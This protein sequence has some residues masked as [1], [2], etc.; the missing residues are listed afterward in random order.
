M[1]DPSAIRTQ[2][3][4]EH[5]EGFPASEV[6]RATGS[7][8]L[9]GNRLE[10]Q[11]EGSS[12]FSSWLEGISRAQC[13]VYLENYLIRNDRVGRA[14]RDVLIEKARSGVPVYVIYD[15]VGCWATRSSYWKPLRQAGVHVRAFNPLS[16]GIGDPFGILRRDHRKLIVLDGK[17]AYVGGFCLGVEWVGGVNQPAWR[18]TAVKISGPAASAAARAFEATWCGMGESL[19]LSQKLPILSDVG[20]TP[21]WLIEGE[22]GRTRVYRTIHWVAARA[23][24][25]I[26][27]TDAYFV[28]PRS[29]SEALGAAAQQGVDVRILV[30]A[31]NNW[32]L[33]GSLS[34][35]GYRSLLKSGVR[36]FEWQGPMI[37]AKTAV[38]DGIWSRVGSSN[39]NSA[40]LIGNW[41]LD[42][43]VLDTKLASQLEDLFLTDLSSSI[44]IVLPGQKLERGIEMSESPGAT[45]SL[46]PQGTLPERMMQIRALGTTQSRITMAPLVRARG[47]LGDSLAGDRPIGREGRTVLGTVSAII[48]STAIIAAFFPTF[49]GAMVAVIAGWFGLTTGIRAY[50]QSRRARS[51]E[52]EATT[53]AELD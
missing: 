51:R 8:T 48:L 41:E 34:R 20:D 46:D 47:A 40:S 17:V 18:D 26:W 50:L 33:V 45:E 36:I 24:E 15:W 42:V 2:N 13:M 23:K 16:F 32:P 35:G 49:V 44:E 30:P 4:R 31:H 52:Q 22:P 11:Y 6:E 3:L 29:V 39:L 19:G 53:T 5:E 1:I 25:R 37:H 12:T 14:F 43:G 28:A 10:L 7:K 9:G 21:V 38:V 27:I